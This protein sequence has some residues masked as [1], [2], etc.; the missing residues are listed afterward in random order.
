MKTKTFDNA[1]YEELE[2]A[3]EALFSSRT[4]REAK[5]WQEKIRYLEALLKQKDLN[6]RNKKVE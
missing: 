2:V 5:F 1:L 6:P 3:K 4:L